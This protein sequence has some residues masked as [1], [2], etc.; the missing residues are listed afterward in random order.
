MPL[1]STM[2]SWLPEA[3]PDLASTVEGGKS[4]SGNVLSNDTNPH[5]GNRV[6]WIKYLDEKGKIQKVFIDEGSSVT[7][8]TIYGSLIMNSDG[9]WKYVSDPYETHPYP[10]STAPLLDN[11][12]YGLKDDCGK[13]DASMLTVQ[14]QDTVPVIGKPESRAVDEDDLA[15]GTDKVKESLVVTGSLAVDPGEDPVDTTFTSQSAPTG[16]KSDGKTVQY[17]IVD[18]GHKLVA[19]TGNINDPVFTVSILNSTDPTGH[20]QYQFTLM[21]ELDHATGAG[22]NTMALTFG[23]QAKDTND[24]DVATS[25]FQVTV[26][27]D[28]PASLEITETATA[29]P[30]DTNLLI[31]LDV[32]GSMYGERLEKSVDA[33]QNLIDA[34]DGMGEVKVA[35]V[36]FSDGGYK[37]TSGGFTWMSAT[38]AKSVLEGW[39]NYSGGGTDYQD[40]LNAAIDAYDDAGKLDTTIDQ[41]V[42]YFISDGH[43]NYTPD[44]SAWLAMVSSEDIISYAFGVGNGINTA[45]LD[46]IA[47]DGLHETDMNSQIVTDVN[48]LS[49]LLASS[50]VQ[51]PLKG[52]LYADFGADGAQAAH[53][54]QSVTI[55]GTTFTYDALHP[56]VTKTTSGGATVKINMTTG[57]Y[58][59]TAPTSFESTYNETISFTVVDGD[60][61]QVA[62]SLKFTNY[63][64]PANLSTVWIGTDAAETHSGTNASD[65]LDGKGGADVLSGLGGDDILKGS[66]GG[67]DLDG[68]TGS[69]ILLGYEGSDK[70][71]F[72]AAD[73]VIDGGNSGNDSDTLLLAS[74]QGID[75]ATLANS[76]LKNIEVVDLSV[77]GNHALTNLSVQDVRDMTDGYNVLTIKGEAGDSVD[78]T[79]GWVA[80]GTSGGY[81]LYADSSTAP[82]VELLIDADILLI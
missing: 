35:V 81:T 40:A 10:P 29:K 17:Q 14:V 26:T 67:D 22:E 39:S 4:T 9:S 16:L 82:T 6:E 76:V 73:K 78:L 61:D 75:F 20:Q 30:V 7:V 42:A 50:V 77:N 27:D 64:L 2:V 5:G 23:Y 38:D 31:T 36:T 25:S 49:G 65:Y 34:Y 13:T 21:K 71:H 28:V 44:Y 41:S 1:L 47:F 70:L 60:G 56:V 11:I 37:Q 66:A 74:G 51:D 32:S 53:M 58:E 59:Y 54:V 72:D 63:P 46:P 80:M 24:L 12:T 48:D 69:D 62:S 55:D 8:N 33:A 68:G 45:P 43:P 19:H 57:A 3:N 79:A 15:W 18:A 52:T